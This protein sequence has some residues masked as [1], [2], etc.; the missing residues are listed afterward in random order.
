MTCAEVALL[1]PDA[2]EAP[3]AGE[4]DPPRTRA[5]HAPVDRERRFDIDELFY[6]RTDGKGIIESGNEVFVRVSGYSREQLIGQAHNIVRHPDMPRALFRV[7]WERLQA[8]A[9]VSA[10][11]KNLAEDGTYYW[12]LAT[13]D[14]AGDGFASV[15]TKPASDLFGAAKAMYADVLAVEQRV[16]GG[17][18]RRRKAA[19]EAGVERLNELLAAAGFENYH[20]FIRAALPAEVQARRRIIGA[21]VRER[22]GTPPLGADPTLEGILDACTA[23]QAVL[24]TVDANLESYAAMHDTLAPKSA[25]VHALADNIRL[26]SLNALLAAT[27]LGSRGAALGAVAEIMGGYSQT[28]GPVSDALGADIAAAVDVLEA[29]D[30]R[31]ALSKL[32][33]ETMM[34]FVRELMARPDGDDDAATDLRILAEG[35][36]AGVRR[37]ATSIEQ[38]GRHLKGISHHAG[39]LSG[40]LKMLSRLEVNGRIEAARLSD[41]GGVLDLFETIGQQVTTAHGEL[42]DFGMDETQATVDDALHERMVAALAVLEER[43]TL[44]SA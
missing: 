30:Y 6:S 29:M 34:V 40:Q 24:D 5:A 17:D 3:E 38:L 7:F 33:N 37:L 1:E 4:G 13:A 20:A 14:A 25:Y 10:Y 11:V 18:V 31:V 36:E 35:L 15:R 26:F 21:S 19:I 28:A 23:T 2:A 27:R 8:G 41:A 12:V 32:Q 44:F 43:M 16:E 39:S 9:A 42:A 22:L